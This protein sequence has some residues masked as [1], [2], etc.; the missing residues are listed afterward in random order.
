MEA[1]ACAA[2]QLLVL[3]CNRCKLLW[4]CVCSYQWASG[5][6]EFFSPDLLEKFEAT[7]ENVGIH[8]RLLAL[9]FFVCLF[10]GHFQ[11]SI[12]RTQLTILHNSP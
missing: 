2:N 10:L 5:W 6:L 1:K 12:K 4:A 7:D 9:F 3:Q 8:C 11:D